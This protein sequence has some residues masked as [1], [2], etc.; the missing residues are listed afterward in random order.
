MTP[1]KSEAQCLAQIPTQMSAIVLPIF[2]FWTPLEA[3]QIL[4]KIPMWTPS[5][6][7]IKFGFICRKYLVHNMSW[8]KICNPQWVV[9]PS[10]EVLRHTASS[11]LQK[12][13]SGNFFRS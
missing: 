12:T 8:I 13:L 10:T 3:A 2:M 11:F 6:G 1:V 9:S 5:F 7:I 4:P